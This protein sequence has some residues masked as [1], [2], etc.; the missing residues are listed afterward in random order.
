MSMTRSIGAARTEQNAGRKRLGSLIRIVAMCTA[1]FGVASCVASSKEM[2]SDAKPAM[3]PQFTAQLF[4]RFYDG[5]AHELQ[6]SSFRWQDGAYV[7]VGGP[8]DL[9]RFVSAPLKGDDSI[10]QGSD[11]SG[12]IYSYWL[13][14]KLADGAYLI[15]PLD[16]GDVDAASRNKFCATQQA[17]G[18]CIVNSKESLIALAEA[19]ARSPI[20]NAEVAVIVGDGLKPAPVILDVRR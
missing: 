16:E 1:S 9:R 4:R 11:M 13:G 18:I 12:K 19:T 6:A 14:R 15:L 17:S 3:G 8:V 10:I 5:K 2:I 20:K 7:N